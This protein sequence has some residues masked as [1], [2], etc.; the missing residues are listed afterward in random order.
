MIVT[1]NECAVSVVEADLHR[2]AYTVP[3]STA[4]VHSERHQMIR[5]ATALA[6]AAAPRTRYTV[7]GNT[8]PLQVAFLAEP[9]ERLVD[10]ILAGLCRH[11]A[12]RG[13]L[14]ELSDSQPKGGI[15][16]SSELQV[17]CC[18]SADGKQ[19]AASSK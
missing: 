13:R 1:W 11:G 9:A 15:F 4:P 6:G 5:G 19:T 17:C 2:L 18:C 8:I 7:D 12:R 14:G 3:A 16:T 10:R